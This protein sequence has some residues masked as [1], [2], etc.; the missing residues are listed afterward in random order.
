MRL[1]LL[2]VAEA[3]RQIRDAAGWWHAN[4]PAARGLFR[5]ELAR[6]FEFITTQP[7]IGPKALDV[8]LAGVR[9]LHLLRIHY[10]LYYRVTD[11]QA[12]E[13]LALWHTSRGELPPI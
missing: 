3:E 10:Y 4:R 5:Q 7:D 2:V 8:A 13:V 12:V 11:D 9:R 1:R 6:G